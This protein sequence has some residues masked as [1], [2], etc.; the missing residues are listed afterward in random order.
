MRLYKL[1]YLVEEIKSYSDLN[2]FPIYM[3]RTD[4]CLVKTHPTKMTVNSD[5]K[6]ATFD[7]QVF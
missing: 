6:Y 3:N 1:K 5:I 2:N 4:L 7:S